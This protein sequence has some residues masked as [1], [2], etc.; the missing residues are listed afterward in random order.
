MNMKKKTLNLA[1]PVLAG[2]I[3]ALALGGCP[4]RPDVTAVV[5]SRVADADSLIAKIRRDGSGLQRMDASVK[6]KL[7]GT[8]MPF[9]GNFYGSLRVDKE[10]EQLALWFQVYNMP[11]V[12]IMEI[13]TRGDRVEVFSPLERTVYVNFSEFAEAGKVEEFPLSAFG[14]VFIPLD[15]I[16]KQIELLW[17]LGIDEAF[18][19]E[20]V[21]SDDIYILSEWDGTVLRREMEYSKKGALLTRVKVYQG[22]ILAGGMECSGHSGGGAAGFLPGEIT[23]YQGDVQ[24]K[25]SL[26]KLRSNLE[27]TGQ[28]IRFRPPENNR[29]VL[30]TPPVR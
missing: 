22:G 26:S 17:G 28:P 13:I 6:I 23:L 24:V 4:K 25:L 11:G 2:I 19:Y 1:P 10:M 9:R 27:V 15:H 20:F 30:L 3:F 5:P 18:R 29:V 7:S 16:V 8:P 12:P 14:E 21:A